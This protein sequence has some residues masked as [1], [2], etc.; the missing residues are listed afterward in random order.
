MGEVR[1]VDDHQ[2]IRPRGNDRMRGFADA[3]KN[4]RQL[5]RDGGQTDDGRVRRSGTGCTIPAAA[6]ARPPTPES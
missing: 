1:A 5:L 6:M 3:A 2:R 4:L